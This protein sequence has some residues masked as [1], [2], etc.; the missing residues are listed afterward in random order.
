MGSPDYEIAMIGGGFSGIACALALF[1]LQ[2]THPTANSR[3]VIIDPGATLPA[4]TPFAGA[5]PE[6]LLN[7]R[8][9][10]MSMYVDHPNDF[11]DFWEADAT[12][13]LSS[14]CADLFAPRVLYARYLA[15]RLAEAR[16]LGADISHHTAHVTGMMRQET[17]NAESCWLIETEQTTIRSRF[18]VLATGACQSDGLLGHARVFQGPWQL[19][20]LPPDPV[21]Q[22]ALIVGGGLSAVDT[23]QSLVHLGWRGNILLVAPRAA[24][25]E[26]HVDQH[27]AIWQLP[28][29]FL[30]QCKDPGAAFRAVRAQ[31]RQARHQQADWRSVI[32]ALRPMTSAI[33]GAWTAPQRAQFLRHL[34]GLWNRH[35]HRAPPSSGAFVAELLAS[36]Q[37]KIQAGRVK[38]LAAHGHIVQADIRSGGQE[39]SILCNLVIDA[40]GG[41][42]RTA[43]LLARLAQDGLLQLSETGFGVL[44][45]D[46]GLA[47]EA[48]YALGANCFGERLETTA[49]PELR[50]QAQRI[51]EHIA[52]ALS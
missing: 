50:V 18:V 26:H 7:V 3:M 16:A 46:D 13:S 33:F 47:G 24:L 9:S 37:L 5:R 51:A 12:E 28:T 48:L 41:C 2:S 14:S 10:Q 31:L 4:G 42:Y 6:H 29:E 38:R 52:I 19:R 43:P 8:A 23:L 30:S 27:V 36:G 17:P 22:L 45:D 32:N 1:Q 21:Q 35:R 40:R 49:V 25:S 44:A 20:H 15:Q 39:Q 34:S 11:C